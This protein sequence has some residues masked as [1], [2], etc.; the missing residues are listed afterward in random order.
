MRIFS[1]SFLPQRLSGRTR[2]TTRKEERPFSDICSSFPPP[3]LLWV[4]QDRMPWEK[5]RERIREEEG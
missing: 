1:Q 3:L 5:G 2:A 4:Q